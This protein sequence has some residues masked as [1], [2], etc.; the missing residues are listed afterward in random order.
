[1]LQTFPT[2][3]GTQIMQYADDLLVS[4]KNEGQVREGTIELLNFLGNNGL[5]VSK[6]KLQFVQPEVRYLGH[7]LGQGG[8]WLS[9]ERIRGILSIPPPR[10][11][12]EVRKLL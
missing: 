10:N 4:G 9:P 8:R 7:V 3:S 12:W 2:T 5:R 11:H 1:L 6:G